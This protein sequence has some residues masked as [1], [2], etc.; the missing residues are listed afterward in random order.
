MIRYRVVFLG[1]FS[2]HGELD[3]E[4]GYSGSQQLARIP[5]ISASL[6]YSVSGAQ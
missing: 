5:K 6:Y 1:A 4:C 2:L 3:S